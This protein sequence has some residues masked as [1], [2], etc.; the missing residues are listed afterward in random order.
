MVESKAPQGRQKAEQWSQFR[1]TRWCE[2]PH[3]VLLCLTQVGLRFGPV[4]HGCNRGVA[5]FVPPGLNPS[6][7][8]N[9][10]VETL[11]YFSIVAPGHLFA[12]FGKASGL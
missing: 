7:C 9:P 4:T 1:K 8:R 12:N 5:S 2:N 11:G 10:S 3:D 6:G